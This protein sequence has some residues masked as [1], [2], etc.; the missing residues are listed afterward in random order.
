MSVTI[1]VV[2]YTAQLSVLFTLIASLGIINKL[3]DVSHVKA[4]S[5]MI[6]A[7]VLLDPNVTQWTVKGPLQAQTGVVVWART[8]VLLD[9]VY[10]THRRI[11]TEIHMTGV[12]YVLS[13]TIMPW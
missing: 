8:A 5:N 3:H 6:P 10:I 4:G 11:V 2:F 9:M 12:P 7:S 1:N 13:Q